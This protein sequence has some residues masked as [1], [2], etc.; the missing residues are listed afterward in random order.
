MARLLS[1]GLILLAFPLA[2]FAAEFRTGD[3]PS[4][5]RGETIQDDLYMAGGSVTSAGTVRGDLVAGGGSV[6][7]SGP[8]T[9]DLMLGGGTVTVLGEISDDI[10]VSGGTVTVQGIVRG[11]ALI[12][13]GQVSLIGER[14][15]GDI[16]IAGGTVRID[17]AIGGSARI[18]GGDVY[19]NAPI[20]GDVRIE[21]EKLTLGPRANIA[22]NLTY[23]AANQATFEDGA[24]VRGETEFDERVGREEAEAGLAAF[25]TFW[26]V[27]KFFMLLVGSLL[28]GVAFNRYSREL[29]AT[30]AAQ[31]LMEFGRGLITI[32]VVPIL[33][34]ILIATIIGIPLGIIG[35][36]ML[37]IM[38]IFASLIA[39]IILGSVVHKLI[40]K[41]ARYEVTWRTIL[42]GVVL[43][44]VIG[45][46]PVIGFLATTILK[47]G[48]LGATLKLKWSLAKEWR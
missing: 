32:I 35:L 8:V 29:V 3:Q 41:P 23:R 26:L 18:A 16:A 34:F 43:Y 31:P 1:A 25:L 39:P 40:W 38:L 28:I 12:G 36:L 14:I 47:M 13:G 9:G 17:A 4:H 20:T 7:V 46:I 48:A 22:G 44:S 24:V 37:A 30:A 19:L 15:G 6:L 2:S 27:A 11:D 33:S 10:R 42:L 45:V 5:P 21:A